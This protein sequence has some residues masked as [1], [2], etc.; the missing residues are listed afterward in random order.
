MDRL[1][2]SIG[3]S[4]G[5]NASGDFTASLQACGGYN[6]PDH[7]CEINISFTPS[8]TGLRTTTFQVTDIDP[9]HSQHL[10]ATL[11]VQGT[12]GVP[13]LELSSNSITFPDTPVG[14][15][16]S[17]SQMITV[18]NNGIVPVYPGLTFIGPNN[19]MYTAGP[20]T[21]NGASGS[22]NPGNSCVFSVLFRPTAVG[23]QDGT[24]RLADGTT[25]S[26]HGSGSASTTPLPLSFSSSTLAFPGETVGFTTGPKAL[27]ITNVGS[28]A[29]DVSIQLLDEQGQVEIDGVF[30]TPQPFSRCYG[31]RPGGSCRIDVHFS[32]TAVGTR[33][34]KLL[35]LSNPAG[36]SNSDSSSSL[37]QTVALSGTGLA[38]VGGPLMLSPSGGLFFDQYGATQPAT[39]ENDG[40]T[41][42]PI[43]WINYPDNNCGTMLAAHAQCVI[44]VDGTYGDVKVYATSSTPYTLP[45][46][47]PPGHASSN[48][49]FIGFQPVSLGSSSS[50]A[51]SDYGT[52]SIIV[53]PGMNA[54]EFAGIG[55]FASGGRGDPCF[56]SLTFSPGAAGL[57]TALVG[58]TSGLTDSTGAAP[59]QKIYKV[60]GFGGSSNGAD[61]TVSESDFPAKI[62][63]GYVGI[64][65]LTNTGT[66]PLLLY[67]DDSNN[68]HPFAPPY[69][70][71]SPASYPG[72]TPSSSINLV[73]YASSG[74]GVYL[75]AGQSC[76]VEVSFD[77]DQGTGAQ[78]QE[79]R[80]TDALSGLS[81][82]QTLTGD[83]GPTE[84]APSISGGGDVGTI[85]V[86]ATTAPATFTIDTPNG[87]GVTVTTIPYQG[88]GHQ[89]NEMT[90]TLDTGTCAQKT[91]C[92]ATLTATPSLTG[93]FYV[94]VNVYDPVTGLRASS[95]LSG[96]AGFPVVTF[97]P[98]S[99]DFGTQQVGLQ[100][101]AHQVTV[102][103]TGQSVLRITGV[104]LISDTA[105]D[106]SVDIGSCGQGTI[107]EGTCTISVYFTPHGTGTRSG[108]L[109]LKS[110]EQTP[111]SLPLAGVGSQ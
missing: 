20:I 43:R 66:A 54:S 79:L 111:S 87:E 107:S 109:Q 102:K 47:V 76:T 15:T 44:Q 19:G 8:A 41:P 88:N 49:G 42:V 52:V 83:S 3:P 85:A 51:V 57:R 1:Q 81:N 6:P 100:S 65:T 37:T 91:P 75:P 60:F 17:G 77:V 80:F 10:S 23:P 2:V 33:T 40:D 110:N 59:P 45:I 50:F 34:P 67:P 94:N 31:L 63:P 13:V 105:A 29:K 73:T 27:T 28:V 26:L 38:S 96:T 53:F 92:Q 25:I 35:F 78:T 12:G 72:C 95:S 74:S 106:F 14:T 101:T 16:T 56:G 9:T 30:S 97:S 11:T 82:S 58:I 55:C 89:S 7:F 99:V 22:L 98:A 39:L 4:T 21:C 46:S 24:M 71:L 108:T 93:G 69:F 90:Y 104:S 48:P 84:N 62:V 5:G 18:K 36:Q 70:K 68:V 61:F 32:P 103:N 64:V 86:G